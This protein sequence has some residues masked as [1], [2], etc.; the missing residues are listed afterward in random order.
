MP[1]SSKYM[2]AVSSLI[3]LSICSLTVYSFLDWFFWC[4]VAVWLCSVFLF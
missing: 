3:K 2:Y 4:R 1:N